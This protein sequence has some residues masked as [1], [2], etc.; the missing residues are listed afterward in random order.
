MHFW[1]SGGNA[2]S[3]FDVRLVRGISLCCT[4]IFVQEARIVARYVIGTRIVADRLN[5][6]I[7]DTS[8]TLY[9]VTMLRCYII[10]L[11]K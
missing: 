1:L 9:D 10:M 5:T 7:I 6:C 2:R 8:C 3:R 11:R 4:C